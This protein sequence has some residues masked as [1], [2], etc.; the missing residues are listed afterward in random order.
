MKSSKL[1]CIHEEIDLYFVWEFPELSKF[2]FVPH[3]EVQ[4]S[5]RV[6]IW[7]RVSN[8]S[9]RLRLSR[10]ISI[11]GMFVAMFYESLALFFVY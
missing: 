9:W 10:L 4:P 6:H 2:E 3:V 11:G 8:R 1:I 7:L 5:V